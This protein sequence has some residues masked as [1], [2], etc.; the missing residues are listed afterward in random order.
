MQGE[1][2]EQMH[3]LLRLIHLIRCDV[4]GERGLRERIASTL[5]R[6]GRSYSSPQSFYDSYFYFFR[7]LGPKDYFTDIL[8]G[9]RRL[10]A[11]HHNGEWTLKNNDKLLPLT[12]KETASHYMGATINRLKDVSEADWNESQLRRLL[13]SISNDVGPHTQIVNSAIPQKHL[14]FHLFLRWALTA[15]RSGP[16][17][18]VSMEILGKAISLQRLT[19]ASTTLLDYIKDP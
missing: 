17:N 11:E 14:D 1:I 2:P 15:G 9:R 12:V 19:D 16:S 18:V 13:E 5:Q 4:A 6:C 8:S 3:R 7:S 10:L